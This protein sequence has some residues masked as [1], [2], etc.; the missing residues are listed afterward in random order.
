MAKDRRGGHVGTLDETEGRKAHLRRPWGGG[1]DEGE[2][3][4]EEKGGRE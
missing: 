4:E 3:V 1:C 2:E